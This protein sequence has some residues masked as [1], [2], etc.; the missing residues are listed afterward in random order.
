MTLLD[1]IHRSLAQSG[2]LPS[3]PI[4]DA[5]F[6]DAEQGVTSR[7]EQGVTGV[8][9]VPADHSWPARTAQG[10][11]VASFTIDGAA[12]GHL[13][14]WPDKSQRSQLICSVTPQL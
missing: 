9:P 6:V 8:G 7:Q 14:G 1:P 4:A 12:P 5:G 10:F 13:P 2:Q 11:A 3:V